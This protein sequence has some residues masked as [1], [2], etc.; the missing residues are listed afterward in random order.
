MSWQE[1][2]EDGPLSMALVV[3][4][5]V[6]WTWIPLYLL[7]S[8]KRVYG[9]KWGMTLLKFVTIGTSYFVLLMIATIFVAIL[10]FVL[11]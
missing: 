8:L 3:V 5:A 7:I 9:Q 11:L 1:P 4:N 10:S 6:A 2:Q